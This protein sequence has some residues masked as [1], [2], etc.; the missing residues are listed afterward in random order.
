MKILRK[1]L[2]GIVALVALLLI[3][4]LFIPKKYTVSVVETI[5]KPK[6]IV[7]EYAKNLKNQEKYSIWVMQDLSSVS[8]K[9]TDGTVGFVQS[10]NSKDDNVG[11]GEQEIVGMTDER[12]DFDL[13]FKRP[14]ESQQKAALIVKTI[15]E[16]QTQV[17]SEFYG[18]DSYPMNLLSFIGKGIIK[19][20]QTK[21]MHNLKEVLE[22]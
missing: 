20:A 3:V 12:L 5:N 2:I 1:I 21:N 6:S 22:K 13:R 4:A 14:F 11:E 19:D 7:F 8:Y 17:V 18:S 16:N 15:S 10:W 9:G